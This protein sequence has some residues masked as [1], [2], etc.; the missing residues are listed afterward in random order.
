MVGCKLHEQDL[1]SKHLTIGFCSLG[2]LEGKKNWKVHRWE[3]R[4]SGYLLQG[5]SFQKL[6]TAIDL[7]PIL[8]HLYHVVLFNRCVT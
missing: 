7:M 1:Y 8:F 5:E 6:K 3:L 4:V 2:F